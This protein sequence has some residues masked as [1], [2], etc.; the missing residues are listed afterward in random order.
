M[1]PKPKKR[2][3]KKTRK[4]PMTAAGW[5]ARV[6]RAAMIGAGLFVLGSIAVVLLFRFVDPPG[7][8]LMVWRA[9]QGETVRREWTDLSRVDPDLVHAIVSAE[10]TKYCRHMGFDLGAIRE[11]INDARAGGRLRGA[12]TLS[13]QTAKNVFLWPG[14]GFVRKG[15]EAWF[16]IL[17]E[18]LWSKERIFEVYINVA[19]WGEGRFGAEIAARELF[20]VSAGAL[21]SEQAARLAAILPAPNAWSADRPGP[22]VRRRVA[23]LRARMVT[24]EQQGGAACI[25]RAGR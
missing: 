1:A 13:Q 19:E 12:S 16:T 3:T 2:N 20:G 22:Y 15:L 11:A 24:V 6:L 5:G 17:I 9:I 8:S 10:D 7:T 18:T 14:R 25:L 21:T 4:T 23:K